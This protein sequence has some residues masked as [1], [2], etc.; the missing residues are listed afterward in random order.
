MEKIVGVYVIQ[1]VVTGASYI[2]SSQSVHH[3]WY[4]HRSL[5]RK[6][7]HH[8]PYLQRSW[9]THGETAFSMRVL[10]ECPMEQLLERE[11]FYIDG[12]RPVYNVS[13]VAG[14]R[15]GVP[16]TTETIERVRKALTG[17][18]RTPE[19]RARMSQAQKQSGHVRGWHNTGIFPDSPE[20][21][22]KMADAKRGKPG[23]NTGHRHSP[24][25]NEKNRIAHLG[26]AYAAGKRT[27]EQI[28]RIRQ[29]QIG[30]KASPETRAK[31]SAAHRGVPMP[32]G[33]G[34]KISATKRLRLAIARNSA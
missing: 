13:A 31:M 17:T 8:A 32:E 20:A 24:E 5:L 7:C 23:N 2:G 25:S 15:R 4:Q 16:Q 18:R 6:G 22:Q 9:N 3:R 28:E 33:T 14:T 26:T 29:G 21:R 19:Q 10:E 11:Q 30:R 27:P 1:N 12:F 34:A